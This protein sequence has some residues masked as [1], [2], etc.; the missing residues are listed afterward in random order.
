MIFDAQKLFRII[1]IGIVILG[2]GLLITHQTWALFQGPRIHLESPLDGTSSPSPVIT[3]SGSGKHLARLVVNNNDTPVRIDGTFTTTLLVAPGYNV[4]RL[5]A[6]DRFQ[7]HTHLLLQ[8]YGNFEEYDL[9]LLKNTG[10]E[11][12]A[13]NPS[14]LSPSA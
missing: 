12:E 11:A 5:D 2:I 10:R 1:G 6:Y 4:I 9:E 14:V 7:K 13:L 3:L 8:I